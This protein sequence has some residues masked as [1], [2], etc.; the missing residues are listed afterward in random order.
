MSAF[1]LC[2]LV[3]KELIHT[4][5]IRCCRRGSDRLLL[6]CN[7]ALSGE[8]HCG[9]RSSVLQSR[10]VNLSR[11]DNAVCDHIAIGLG[12]CIK[13]ITDLAAVLDLVYYNSAFNASICLLYTSH[14]DTPKKHALA[15]VF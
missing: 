7:K 14:P 12:R 4:S 6:V 13:A 15:I 1:A 5:H 9:N 10:A 2:F 8:D 11:I 3:W